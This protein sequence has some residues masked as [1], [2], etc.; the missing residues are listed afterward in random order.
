MDKPKKGNTIT[1]KINGEQKTFQEQPQKSEPKSAITPTPQVLK[2]DPEP[3][4]SVDAF[5]ETAAAQESAD[6]SF[7]WIIPESSEEDNDKFPVENNPVS[8]QSGHKMASFSKG[9]NKKNGPTSIGSVLF[10][11]L[12][13]IIIGTGI[14]FFMLKLVITEPGKNSAA[15]PKTVE[16]TGGTDKTSQSAKSASAVIEQMTT[17]IIQGGIY[18][19]PDGAKQT[20][21]QLAAKGIPSQLISLNGKSYIFLG[22]ADS[23]ETAKSLS[24]QYKQIGAVDAFAKPLLVDGKNLSNL[25]K[26]EKSFLET[27]PAV[28]KT[29]ANAAATALVSNTFPEDSVKALAD[30][31]KQLTATVKSSKVKKL[32][33]QLI[34]AADKIKTYQQS[35]DTKSLN[36]AEQHL[37]NYLSLYYSL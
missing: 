8:K 26:T 11:A 23:I 14:G 10:S 24:D 28:Y 19:S 29:L 16:T 12:F 30:M 5:S 13:A 32:Q 33:E 6:E 2:I 9:P 27:M 20:V 3:T 4:E 18:S 22:V 37:L 7:D 25:S 31:E 17:Y 21:K 15:A 34:S 36:D 1:I 35:K